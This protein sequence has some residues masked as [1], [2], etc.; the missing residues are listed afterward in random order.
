MHT[1]A[2]SDSKLKL[3]YFAKTRAMSSAVAIATRALGDFI[4]T[5]GQKLEKPLRICNQSVSYKGDIFP[6]ALML[7]SEMASKSSQ[8]QIR[9]MEPACYYN[10]LYLR[11]INDCLIV[12]E[13][14]HFVIS[15]IDPRDRTFDICNHVCITEQTGTPGCF[16]VCMVCLVEEF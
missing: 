16:G 2:R 8:S 3:A 14:K 13:P 6:H 5:R 11:Y 12:S 15:A 1:F 9:C 4:L 10:Y 7:R